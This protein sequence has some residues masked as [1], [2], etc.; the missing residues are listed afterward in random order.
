MHFGGSRGVF[1]KL[2]M[3]RHD[4]VVGDVSLGQ[5]Q[6]SPPGTGF[7]WEPSPEL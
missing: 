3:D 4:A 5:P 1:Q 7:F 6:S 2:R